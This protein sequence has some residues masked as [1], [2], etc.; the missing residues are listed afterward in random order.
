MSSNVEEKKYIAFKNLFIAEHQKN[1]HITNSPNTELKFP[2]LKYCNQI[3]N[4]THSIC[5]A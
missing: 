5:V 4:N 3:T 1:D 2:G